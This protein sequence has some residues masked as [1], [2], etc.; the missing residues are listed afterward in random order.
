MA[1]VTA[2]LVR[3]TKFHIWFKE[4]NGV[5]SIDKVFVPGSGSGGEVPRDKEGPPNPEG[6]V[7]ATI[8]AFPGSTCLSVNTGGGFYWVCF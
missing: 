1:I 3:K 7:I 6:T 4:E 5:V 2:P 8:V